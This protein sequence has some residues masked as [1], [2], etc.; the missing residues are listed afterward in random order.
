MGVEEEIIEILKEEKIELALTLPCEKMRRF[1]NMLSS[2]FENLPVSREEESV[3]I[4]AGAYFAG[5]RSIAVIQ[6]SGIG[7]MINALCSLTTTYKLPF[8]MLVSYR[9]YK[10]E[11][12]EAQKALGKALPKILEEID[13]SYEIVENKN[14]IDKIKKVVR[15][16][17]SY[18]KISAALILPT[19]WSEEDVKKNRYEDKQKEN[20]ERIF[21]EINI[22]IN[23][24]K[25]EMKRHEIIK[26]IADFVDESYAIV[27]NL[28]MPSR[29]LYR[30]RHRKG[31]FY[32]L[33]SM[34][35]AS[36][37]A[38]GISLFV[39]K[40][41]IAIEGDG[42][43]LMNPGSLA[44]IAIKQ[45]ENLCIFA[46]D[47]A[48]YSTTGMQK[49]ASFYGADLKMLAIAMG[50]RKAFKISKADEIK[51]I[52]ESLDNAR[53]TTFAHVIAEPGNME[54]AGIIPLKPEEIKES[55]MKF[56]KKNEQQ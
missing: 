26:C 6:S 41:V 35:L 32:M 55:F 30:I 13:A 47:N 2:E 25:P 3:G 31:N 24:K 11:K 49:T 54:E 29:E 50:I 17:Y 5:A 14:D 34:G 7:N 27:C 46:I 51:Q 37:I 12:I 43:L 40:R 15:E 53:E 10:N 21:R 9:G 45:P 48:S 52:L 19:F 4:A 56:L 23:T 44:T 33:G 22:K 20:E 38:F 18:D 36:S 16:A 42:S 28:G 39:D 1:I 8:P